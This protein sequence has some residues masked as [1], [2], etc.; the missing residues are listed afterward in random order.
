KLHSEKAR[1]PGGTLER[2]SK[3][4]RLR[5]DLYDPLA[6]AG[7]MAEVEKKPSEGRHSIIR[8][9]RTVQSF[10]LI[11][12]FESCQKV[13][14]VHSYTPCLNFASCC[15]INWTSLRSSIAKKVLSASLT[16]SFTTSS[17]FP[18]RKPSRS[19]PS[20]CSNTFSVSS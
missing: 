12:A 7:V 4:L 13:I 19:R 2:F 8:F 15:L 17:S 18:F 1:F 11:E 5:S 6:F 10:S 16:S 14:C 20:R 3:V 9:K